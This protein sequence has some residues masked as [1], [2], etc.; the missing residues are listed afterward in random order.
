MLHFIHNV[1]WVLGASLVR[2]PCGIKIIGWMIRMMSLFTPDKRLIETDTLL[3]FHHPT[4][5]YQVHI[6]IVP[7][8]PYHDLM[9]LS[10]QDQGFLIDLV[11]SVQELVRRFKLEKLGWRLITNGGKYQD[12][13]YLHFRLIA[14][15]IPDSQS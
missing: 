14:E 8:T 13:P 5:S 1:G 11:S 6:L 9:E 10:A 4:P 12:F 3:A 2:L 7:K 15:L